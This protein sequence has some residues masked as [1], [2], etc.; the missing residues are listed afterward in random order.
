VS[1]TNRFEL[2]LHAEGEVTK[3]NTEVQEEEKQ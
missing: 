1:D 2:I 3:G